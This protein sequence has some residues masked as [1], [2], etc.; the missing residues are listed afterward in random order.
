[1]T[2][3]INLN[4]VQCLGLS[5]A[6][7]QTSAAAC[8]AAA[9]AAEMNLWQWCPPSGCNSETLPHNCW[10]GQLTPSMQ[11][12]PSAGWISSATNAS[13]PAPPGPPPPPPVCPGDRACIAYDDSAWRNVNT[14]HDFIDEGV[15]NADADRN[16][17][18]LPFNSGCR[19][20]ASWKCAT[21]TSTISLAAVSYYRKHFDIPA[22][23]QGCVSVG[24]LLLFPLASA[25]DSIIAPTGAPL[26]CVPAASPSGSTLTACTAPRTTGSTASGSGTTSLA[27]RPCV[28]REGERGDDQLVIR[29]K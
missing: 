21:G 12:A 4:G 11:C 28:Q 23:W 7:N 19:S 26:L 6:D 5:P 14:P 25:V 22:D 13:F 10:V 1:M 9:C 3:P 15:P 24:G 2:Y 17:G 29:S 16:H 8:Q 27:T 20:V 18:Y